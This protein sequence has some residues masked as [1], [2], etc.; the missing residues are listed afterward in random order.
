MRSCRRRCFTLSFGRRRSTAGWATT[1]PTRTSGAVQCRI[2]SSDPGRRQSTLGECRARTGATSSTWAIIALA[3]QRTLIDICGRRQHNAAVQARRTTAER[4]SGDERR[5]HAPAT[6]DGTPDPPA[7]TAR[8]RH[9]RTT[10][11][12]GRG[13]RATFPAATPPPVGRA[14]SPDYRRRFMRSVTRTRFER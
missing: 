1:L 14:A 8:R 9:N 5:R 10:R 4:G 3:G 12:R 7:V 13:G 2:H 11:T 6:S